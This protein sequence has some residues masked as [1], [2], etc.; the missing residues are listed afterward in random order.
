MHDVGDPGADAAYCK[1]FVLELFLEA[2]D[3]AL[4]GGHELNVV[5]CCEADVAVAV[6]VCD[7]QHLA[8]GNGAKDPRGGYPH[9]KDLV[10]AV[11]LVHHSAGI[12]P[13]VM[14]PVAVVLLDDRRQ[15]LLEMWRPDVCGP[16]FFCLLVC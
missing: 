5:P 1:A 12:K 10:A 11:G 8:D 16:H 2:L 9:R 6:L 4:V 13:F 14:L 15:E 3:L 7:V